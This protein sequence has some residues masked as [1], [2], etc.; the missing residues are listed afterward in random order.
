MRIE[1][2]DEARQ[3][4]VDG[5]RFYENQS[6]GLGDYFLDALFSDID[7]LHIYAGVHAVHFGHHRLLARRFPFAVYYSVAG[8]VIRVLAVLDCRRDPMCIRGRLE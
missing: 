4:L 6:E 3:D 8:N 1:V 2:L 5:F 7:S